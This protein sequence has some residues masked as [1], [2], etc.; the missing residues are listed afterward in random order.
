M[1][2]RN[3][4]VRKAKRSLLVAAFS[5]CGMFAGLQ[6]GHAMDPDQLRS[7]D[8]AALLDLRVDA[9]FR[10]CGLPAAIV[11]MPDAQRGRQ[12][13]RWDEVAMSLS[14][15]KWEVR[16]S[17]NPA[18]EEFAS[19]WRNPG[20]A[21]VACLGALASLRIEAKGE[22]GVLSVRKREDGN[23]YVTTYSI[24]EDLY[25]AHQVVAVSAKLR[26]GMPVSAIRKIY[27]APDEILAQT[28]GTSI[29]RYWVVHRENQMPLSAY[30][31]DFE[32]ES[33]GKICSGYAFYTSG[34]QFVQEKLDVFIQAW[35]RA[36]VLD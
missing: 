14:R 30:A 34:V 36:Y 2:L 13:L 27:G 15:A 17:R 35:Q 25:A 18:Q 8:G 10:K 4:R 23:G 7:L 5:L 9:L 22:A 3:T 20:K 31:V 26:E 12:A 21:S 32:V 29:H 33:G 6:S 16:Y 11:D 24:P 19:G 28:R 1:E